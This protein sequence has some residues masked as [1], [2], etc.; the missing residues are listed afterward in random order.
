MSRAD[1]TAT[2]V[3]G[4]SAKNPTFAFRF[5]TLKGYVETM[6]IA[7][8]WDQLQFSVKGRQIVMH[9]SK[10]LDSEVVGDIPE[11]LEAIQWGFDDSMEMREEGP[12]CG[13]YVGRKDDVAKLREIRARYDDV[14]REMFRFIK[15][16][17]A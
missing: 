13:W 8:T 6:G 3:S 4:K 11:S 2:S 17:D 12:V 14:A 9:N 10:T 7:C 1:S 16:G 15:F 5:I